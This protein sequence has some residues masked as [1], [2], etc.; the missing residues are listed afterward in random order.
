[1]R[2]QQEA[3]ALAGPRRA[4][5][6]HLYSTGL[7]SSVPEDE[8]ADQVFCVSTGPVKT[9]V[10]SAALGMV[11]P[12]INVNHNNKTT[13]VGNRRKVVL[14]SRSVIQVLYPRP[15]ASSTEWKPARIHDW[16]IPRQ[17]FGQI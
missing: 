13:E 5:E 17:T 9:L 2:E 6:T 11:R 7:L 16:W 3:E 10:L 1:V 4:I 15:T 12:G 14:V 8:A